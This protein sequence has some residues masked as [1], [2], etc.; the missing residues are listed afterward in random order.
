M[1]KRLKIGSYE[2]GKMRK[3]LKIRSYEDMK[4]GKNRSCEVG[5]I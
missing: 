5:K 4:I 3:R 1:R 2:V